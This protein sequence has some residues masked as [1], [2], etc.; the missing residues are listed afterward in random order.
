MRMRP[1]RSL[2]DAVVLGQ[3]RAPDGVGAQLRLKVLQ[4]GPAQRA[5]DAIGAQPG[6]ELD[7]YTAVP[8][9]QA[10]G[11]HVHL[12]AEVL[13]GPQGERIVIVRSEPWRHG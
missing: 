11:E 7:A 4:C 10:P 2:L 12:E 13:G 9:A 1:N 5:L 6:D 3:Q 8:E